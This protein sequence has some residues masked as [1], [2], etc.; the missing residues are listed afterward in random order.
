[1]GGR[2]T[3]KEEEKAIFY[4]TPMEISQHGEVGYFIQGKMWE[5]L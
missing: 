1:L 3:K 4:P 2:K 5:M